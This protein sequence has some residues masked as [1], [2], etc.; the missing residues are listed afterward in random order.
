MSFHGLKDDLAQPEAAHEKAAP[1]LREHGLTRRVI[2]DLQV[3][4][5]GCRSISQALMLVLLASGIAVSQSPASGGPPAGKGKPVHKQVDRNPARNTKKLATT[6]TQPNHESVEP[7][8]TTQ[9]RL[10]QPPVP[11]APL[12][13]SQ[14]P[15]SPP[16]IIYAGGQLTVVANNSNL[17]DVLNGIGSAIGAGIQGNVAGSDERV[18]GQFGPASPAAVLD[19]LLLGS[20]YDFIIVGSAGN[21]GSVAQI[22]LTPS[23]IDTS[24]QQSAQAPVQA[25]PQGMGTN[26]TPFVNQQQASSPS[27]DEPGFP[28]GPGPGNPAPRARRIVHAQPLGANSSVPQPGPDPPE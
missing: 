8:P 10:D 6:S 24:G 14:M 12:R 9:N 11:A 21:P 25:L 1:I 26:A 3:C 13:P 22:I 16:R 17:A 18:F 27:G 15:P 5:L 19:T 28:P 4:M 7:A 20:H 2:I 23:S